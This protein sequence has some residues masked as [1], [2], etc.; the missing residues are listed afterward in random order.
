MIFSIW[1]VLFITTQFHYKPPMR[2]ITNL[3]QVENEDVE[4]L[5]HLASTSLRCSRCVN[6]FSPWQ[7]WRKFISRK[8]RLRASEDPGS[9]PST[10]VAAHKGF[11][12]PFPGNLTLSSGRH[13]HCM[14]LV[15]RCTCKQN[16]HTHTNNKQTNEYKCSGNKKRRKYLI[17]G[18]REFSSWP[19]EPFDLALC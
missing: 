18:F 8:K 15:H 14:H 10:Y 5:R 4:R 7:Y 1:R 2:A 3:R 12:T 13:W 6:P 9:I 11:V 19:R 16:S 17:T